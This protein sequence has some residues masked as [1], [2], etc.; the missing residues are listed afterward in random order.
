MPASVVLPRPGGPASSTWSSVS[1]RLRAACTKISSCSLAARLADEVGEP[2]AA[3]ALSSRSRSSGSS[4]GS[5]MRLGV[6]GIT[7]RR[8]LLA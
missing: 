8:L 2:L 6:V 1:P 5:A 4:L 3:A 7:S